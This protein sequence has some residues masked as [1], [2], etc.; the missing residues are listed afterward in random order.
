MICLFGLSSAIAQKTMVGY[1]IE[2]KD[3]KVY[4]DLGSSTVKLGDRLKVIKEGGIL[5]HPVTGDSI[6]EEDEM[7]SLIEVRD[8]KEKYSITSTYDRRTYDLVQI[9]MK[10]FK[11]SN[12]ESSTLDVRKSVIVQPLT[13]TN[14]QGFLGLYIDEILTGQ[15]L[16]SDRFKVLDRNTIGIKNDELFL[17]ANGL[18]SESEFLDYPSTKNADYF[19]S[20][21]MYEPDVVEVS[22]GVPVKGLVNLAGMAVSM[23]TGKDMSRLSS[24]AEYL[25][26]KA[27]FKNVKAIVKISLKIIDVKTGEILFICTEMQEAE[28]RSEINMEGGVLNG[29]KVRGGAATFGNTV[30]GEATKKCLQ[31]LMNY[32]FQYFDGK[33]TV[34]N[35]TGNTLSLSKG[36]QKNQINNPTSQLVIM[37]TYKAVEEIPTIGLLIGE[38]DEG[39]SILQYFRN[40]GMESVNAA[41]HSYIK[42]EQNMIYEKVIDINSLKKGDTLFVFKSFEVTYGNFLSSQTDQLVRF[43]FQ[44]N[45]VERIG[46]APLSEIYS[47]RKGVPDKEYIKTVYPDSVYQYYHEKESRV[48]MAKV[49]STLNSPLMSQIEVLNRKGD[50]QFFN[51]SNRD[52]YLLTENYKGF[53]LED[54]VYFQK[55]GRKNISGIIVGFDPIRCTL[56]IRYMNLGNG[57][58]YLDTADVHYSYVSKNEF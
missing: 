56:R 57:H 9:G 14:V 39:Q 8:V 30:T 31:G 55:P 53:K 28:G 37:P 33:I 48:V 19:I 38:N 50:K 52:L 45:N 34:K 51:C 40:N 7:V 49:I 47:I 36:Q 16:V 11:L 15:L 3:N 42:F 23:A 13:V 41:S 17:S 20:G 43:N 18:I 4:V 44:R 12:E 25:P 24:V 5:I 6:K 46:T 35:Y 22:T 26:E 10:V 1:V 27:E 32:V 21:T 2:K 58:S 54:V 29:L